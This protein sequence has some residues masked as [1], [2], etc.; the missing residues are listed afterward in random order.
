MGGAYRLG[1]LDIRA[2]VDMR[3]P[4]GK[5]DL[6]FGD[7]SVPPFASLS[8][9]MRNLGW[10]ERAPIQPRRRGEGSGGE[11]SPRMGIR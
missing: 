4:D 3:S 9:T 11:L 2:M 1:P 5:T 8:Q 6:R 7:A 10:R